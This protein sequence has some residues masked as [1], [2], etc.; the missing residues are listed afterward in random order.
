VDV[1]LFRILICILACWAIP[2]STPV[3][4]Q[5]KS[6]FGTI[7]R[8]NDSVI[9]RFELEQRILMLEALG[10]G[11]STREIALDNLINERLYDQAGK[12]LGIQ[13]TQDE[14]DRGI[15]EFAARGNL[16]KDELLQYL[17]DN[18]VEEISFRNFVDAGL[19]WR[20]VVQAKFARK[21]AVQDE[22]IENS[23][24]LG[25]S[26]T[27]LSLLISEIVLPFQERGEVETR[28]L[29]QELSNSIRGADGFA[30]A[31]ARYS[32]APTAADGGRLEW[33]SANKIAPRIRTQLLALDPG[34]IT[35]PIEFSE[36]VG[37]FMLRGVRTERVEN[38]LPVS[39]NYLLV[40]LPPVPDA[41]AEAQE[42]IGRVDTCM[43]LRAVAEKYGEGATT[44]NTVL[45]SAAPAPVA[46]ELAKLDRN[47]TIAF[48]N[49]GGQRSV[50]MLCSR[51]RD[52][53]EESRDGL[54]QALFN[55]RISGFGDS[56]LQEL[57]GQAFIELK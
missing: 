32:S 33:T 15:E 25:S 43:D 45:A 27:Q 8:V 29:A 22:E 14:I 44:E 10:T 23:L 54:R 49:S 50:V 12:R 46:R 31:A 3:A 37:I 7:A 57:K 26:Q 34:Q 39:L 40:N 55:E 53:P 52:L 38:P 1:K 24:N 56:Y 16:G 42:L 30:T 5:G 11:G 28:R 6:A 2:L 48:T 20:A 47:E 13:V 18:G 51:I 19:K 41:V 4:A 17:A 9:T 21:A 35:P 36:F